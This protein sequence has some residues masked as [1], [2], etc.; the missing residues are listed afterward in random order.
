MISTAGALVAFAT[1]LLAAQ[2][3]RDTAHTA[4]Q[5]LTVANF[6]WQGRPLDRC[7]SFALF[8]LTYFTA[9][10][11]SKMDR[12]VTRPGVGRSGWDDALAI[13]FVSELGAWRDVGAYSALG[14]TITVGSVQ[15]G[16]KPV[17][18]IG[19]RKFAA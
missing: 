1:A 4:L 3:A 7:R 16:G 8:E 13:H 5:L 17:R 10:V 6:C 12:A 15:A 2:A 19:G 14:G 11:G 18:I 9:V